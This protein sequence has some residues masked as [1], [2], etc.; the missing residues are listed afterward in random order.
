MKKFK[1]TTKY[2]IN[3]IKNFSFIA[4]TLIIMLITKVYGQNTCETAVLL[5]PSDTVKFHTIPV[6]DTTY[7]F[8]FVATDS[9]V[10]IKMQNFLSDTGYQNQ[11]YLYHALNYCNNYTQ[12]Y[13]VNGISLRYNNLIIGDTYFIKLQNNGKNLKKSI[14]TY[15]KGEDNSSSLPNSNLFNLTNNQT[16]CVGTEVN[17]NPALE[18]YTTSY[19]IIVSGA[20]YV[21]TNSYPWCTGIIFDCAFPF[22]WINID[23]QN[24]YGNSSTTYTGFVTLQPDFTFNIDCS[25]VN[26][27]ASTCITDPIYISY[28]TYQ[29]NY[30]NGIISAPSSNPNNTYVYNTFGTYNVTLSVIYNNPLINCNYTA[31]ISH[32]VVIAPIP[33]I[34]PKI[35]GFKNDCNDITYYSIENPMPCTDYFWTLTQGGTI[36]SG[37]GSA[38]IMIKFDHSI[39]NCNKAV[40]SVVATNN[41]GYYATDEIEI[42]PCCNEPVDY[43]FN[44]YTTTGNL[45]LP[46]GST[47]V[48]NGDFIMHHDVSFEHANVHVSPNSKIILQSSYITLSVTDESVISSN[49]DCCTDMWDGIYTNNY[50]Q[51][52]NI[53]NSII[54]NAQ[55]ALNLIGGTTFI[56]ENSTFVDNYKNIYIYQGS[57]GGTP[58]YN[59]IIR[60][61]YFQ[62]NNN[63]Q[64]HPYTG[65]Q[66]YSGIEVFRTYMMTI[67]DESSSSYINTF[68]NMF[69]GIKTEQSRVNIYNNS[70]SD[71]NA[72]TTPAGSNPMQL[73]NST[74]I[75]CLGDNVI[76]NNNWHYCEIG[77]TGFKQNVFRNCFNGIYAFNLLLTAEN[78]LMFTYNYG[79][80]GRDLFD[81]SY[82]INNL[83]YGYIPGTNNT[84][85][86]IRIKNIQPRD[87][88]YTISLNTIN[89]IQ[90]GVYINNA[91]SNAANNLKVR[92]NNNNIYLSGLVQPQF[93]PFSG[94]LAGGCYGIT[95]KNNNLSISSINIPTSANLYYGVDVAQVR[96]AD[97][98]CNT[99]EY[100]GA[101]ININGDC[102]LSRFWGNT[103]KDC[104]YGF[105]FNTQSTISQQGYYN[106]ALSVNSENIWLGN[107][108]QNP[109]IYR[110]LWANT[111]PGSLHL[112]TPG[113]RWYVRSSPLIYRLEN[114]ANNTA[115]FIYEDSSNP[116]NIF[117]CQTTQTV[118]P[119][120][121]VNAQHRDELLA[122]IVRDSNNY[123]QLEEQYKAYD[124][125]AVYKALKEDATLL[126]MGA[127]ND[128][129]YLQFFTEMTTSNVEKI[130][131]IENLIKNRED[132]LALV[133][134]ALLQNEKLIDE[135]RKIVNE[136]YLT[137]F[138]RG[139]YDLTQEQI[140]ILMPIATRYTPWEGGDAVYIARNMLNLDMDAIEADFAKAPPKQLTDAAQS[141][142]KL[143]PNPAKDEVMIEFNHALKANA[144]LE[145]YGFAGN[146]LQTSVLQSGYQFIS[147]SVKELKSGIYY[148]RIIS[149]SEV[150]EKNKLL[151]IK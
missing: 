34:T 9:A 49:I 97:I 126:N 101:G 38:N 78:N 39:S 71:I 7:W 82:I 114:S 107:Y 111:N 29:W 70:F 105:Y 122:D 89:A 94:I 79:I 144:M 42:Y 56:V 128:A 6:T 76:D 121:Y 92:V 149:N 30:G 96:N 15:F 108:L 53:Q 62:G 116:A 129:E 4:L 41:Q 146:L 81:Y 77:G 11:I 143:Y 8:K 32:N 138:A 139:N 123:E 84:L 43:T 140:N 103:L 10:N 83:I 22:F 151:I 109:G 85:E 27:T 65:V 24:S 125:E 106:G 51:E 88:Y 75:F 16:V 124:K 87:C 28:C 18:L 57:G 36:E 72:V 132:S 5:T 25:V 61:N 64:Y 95:I 37:Q 137:T 33:V 148:Y 52:V 98:F 102:K 134:N 80:E 91:N 54:T 100:Y 74:A 1:R 145:I 136:I 127:A 48:I 26:L 17:F 73:Y 21:F 67:G 45:Y 35:L 115:P 141:N 90:R 3:F 120:T 133:K 47:V 112:L 130:S 46:Y 113:T 150:I 117:V 66:T 110:K 118:L 86:G 63:L 119:S 135:L 14:F 20:N 93:K 13:S 44:N 55:N 58:P 69:C 68:E 2:F 131:E 40:L 50:T 147:V 104:F 19:N 59:G 99:S 23:A 60:G 31:Q 142:A 12:I